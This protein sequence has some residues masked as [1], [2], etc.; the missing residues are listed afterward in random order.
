MNTVGGGADGAWKRDGVGMRRWDL[1]SEFRPVKGT[2]RRRPGSMVVRQGLAMGRAEGAS[3]ERCLTL[4][5]W[6]SS[7]HS[8]SQL[9][10]C[11]SPSLFLSLFIF[12]VLG[13]EHGLHMLGKHS[14]SELQSHPIF[15]FKKM[16]T[17]G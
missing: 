3:Q 16:Q 6:Q 1:G 9:P 4:D 5:R 12:A 8:S 11:P 7:L 10:V 2:A 13:I 17:V 14:V 15:I